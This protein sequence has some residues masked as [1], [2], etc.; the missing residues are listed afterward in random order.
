MVL[1]KPSP[2]QKT[3]HKKKEKSVLVNPF[4]RF[5]KTTDFSLKLWVFRAGLLNDFQNVFPLKVGLRWFFFFVDGLKWFQN[6]VLGCKNGS[7][8]G[9]NPL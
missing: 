7:K 9:R 5:T 8:V 3:L 1:L 6:G 4:S 2:G